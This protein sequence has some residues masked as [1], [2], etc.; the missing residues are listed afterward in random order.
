MLQATH[1]DDQ[2]AK[3][4][5]DTPRTAA[6]T[7]NLAGRAT[8]AVY[9]LSA[10]RQPPMLGS[11]PEKKTS[12]GDIQFGPC[13]ERSAR[14]T[15]DGVASILLPTLS[16]PPSHWFTVPVVQR[17]SEGFLFGSW[18]HDVASLLVNSCEILRNSCESFAK[19]PLVLCEVAKR[20]FR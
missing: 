18:L 16:P 12:V 8:T 19:F 6:R 9:A 4:E 5:K 3:N 13:T 2:T 1:W 7:I 10:H 15:R 14:V 17:R 11:V 20:N